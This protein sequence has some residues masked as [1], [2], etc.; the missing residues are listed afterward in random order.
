MSNTY[1]I[2]I[3][4]I[5][6]SHWSDWFDNATI[7]TDN[8]NSVLTCELIDQAALYSLLRKVRDAGLELQSVTRIDANTNS[9]STQDN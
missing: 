9:T 3:N 5:L 8:D 6:D 4:G 2:R 1:E 7:T